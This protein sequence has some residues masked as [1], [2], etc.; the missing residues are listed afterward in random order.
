MTALDALLPGP[1]QRPDPATKTAGPDAPAQDAPAREAPVADTP[2]GKELGRLARP[3]GRGQKA[4]DQPAEDIVVAEAPEEPETPVPVL[5][6][7]AALRAL[8]GAA[9]EPGTPIAPPQPTTTTDSPTRTRA[10][11]RT[12]WNGVDRASAMTHARSSGSASGTGISSFAGTTT[13]SA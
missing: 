7:Q 2:F 3:Q 6:P 4:A 11:L 5:D 8:F 10:R 13:Y 12:A 9:Q 1:R